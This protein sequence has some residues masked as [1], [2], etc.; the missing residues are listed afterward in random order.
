MRRLRPTTLS[1]SNAF[2]SNRKASIMPKN[3]PIKASQLL[4]T[5]GTCDQIQQ[6]SSE[7]GQLTNR[8]RFR[9][10]FAGFY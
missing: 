3:F 5:G 2:R 4:A 6:N 8:I 10:V 9:W 1:Q 7:R